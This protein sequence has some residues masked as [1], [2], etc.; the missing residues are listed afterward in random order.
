MRINI[1]Q[2]QVW[3]VWRLVL[4][5]AVVVALVSAARWRSRRDDDSRWLIVA[6]DSAYTIALD[7]TRISSEG[8]HSY[9]IWYRTDH[10]AKRFYREKA[11]D[12]EVVQAI[13]GC[14]DLR[15]RIV[16]SEMSVRG[17]LVV[18]RQMLDEKEVA[19]EQ[20]HQ[21]EAGS[22]DAIVAREACDIARSRR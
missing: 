22:T 1:P 18:E 21:V 16:S 6:S 20:W 11:F 19:R 17:G 3:P 10:S 9:R 8:Q 7:T 2:S 4:T 15:Y 12:R 13:L 14:R 5:P